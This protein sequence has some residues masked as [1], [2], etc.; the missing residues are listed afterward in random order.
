[1]D[2]ERSKKILFQL[3]IVYFVSVLIVFLI[4][5]DSFSRERINGDTLSPVAVV[6]EQT[7]GV[8]L[9]QKLSLPAEYVDSVYIQAGT[10]GRENSGE[11]IVEMLDAEGNF[12]GEAR[13]KA[14]A[15]GDGSYTYLQFAEPILGKRGES[16]NLRIVSQGSIPGN[17]IALYYG[18]SVRTGRFDI[19]LNVPEKERYLLNGEIGAG[20]LCIYLSGVNELMVSRFYWPMMLILYI[21]I[22]GCCRIWWKQA[23]E[24]RNNPL[25]MF[26]T[27]ATRYS[28]LMRQLIGRDF[29]TKY[30]R[31]VLGIGWSF[32]NPLL[33][34]TVQYIVFSTLFSNGT[35]NY[36]V[37]LLSGIVLFNF[38]NEAVSLGMGSI[39]GNASLI[40]KVYVPKYIYPVSRVFSSLINLGTSMIPLL[41]V[42]VLTGTVLKPSLLLLVFDLC[43]LVMFVVGMVLILST[44][45]TFFQDTQFLWGVASMAWMYL[46]P[47]F[48]TESIIPEKLLFLYHMNPMYQY[49]T[50]ARICIIEGVSPGPTAYLW[51]IISALAVF[52]FGVFVFKKNQDKFVLNL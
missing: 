35:K 17:A 27:L 1:M 24:G 20:R 4:A 23:K 49:I 32:L 38:F 37:Y 51:C 33:T 30:K 39:V 44:S 16:V 18:N 48:Y 45:M 5:A 19:V 29:K 22:A 14:A 15:F 40:K 7:D 47:I 42:M 8:V 52:V 6:C 41:A 46:T 50:F 13:G 36:P 10:F 28:F 9:E 25:V 26:C 34:M 43:C 11:I 3:T 21:V 12:L 2:F 31:S